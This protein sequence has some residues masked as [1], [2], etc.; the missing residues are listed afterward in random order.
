[1]TL[2]NPVEH[3]DFSE[4]SSNRA[5]PLC[6]SSERIVLLNLKASAFCN[7]NSTY[8]SDY[9]EILG[10]SADSAFPISRCSCCQ[11]VYASWLPPQDFLSRVYDAVIDEEI[12]FSESLRPSWLGHLLEITG[13][14][15]KNIDRSELRSTYPLRVLDYGCG[16]GAQLRALSGLNYPYKV[17]GFETSARALQ[18]LES[19]GIPAASTLQG[20]EA[21]GPYH[22]VILSEILEHVPDFIGAIRYNSFLGPAAV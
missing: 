22:V 7:I 1:M 16:Y 17:V 10:I 9:P 15:L 2:D 8:R 13:R 19:A 6:G 5:C 14:I 3:E 11:F 12:G 20:V 18:Y 4:V 21:L